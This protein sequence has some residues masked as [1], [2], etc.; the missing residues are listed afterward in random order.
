MTTLEAARELALSLPEVSEED[1]HG[2]DSWRVR[3]KIFA[4]VPDQDHIRVM[5]EEPEVHAAVEEN[6]SCCEP[7]YWGSRLAC[8]VVSLPRAEAGLV[9]ELLVEAWCRKAPKR[10]VQD[11]IASMGQVGPESGPPG[12]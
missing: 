6:P 12:R 4:T 8:V 7:F 3:G 1:H 9:R 10:L 5:V 11:L 2:M